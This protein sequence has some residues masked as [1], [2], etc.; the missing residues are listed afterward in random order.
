MVKDKTTEVET[1]QGLMTVKIETDVDDAADEIKRG[2]KTKQNKATKKDKVVAVPEA[3][4]LQAE[5]APVAPATTETLS[6]GRR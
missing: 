1:S 6:A 2:E 5:R 4:P 3:V